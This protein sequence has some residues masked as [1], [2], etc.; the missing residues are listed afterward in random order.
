MEK[1]EDEDNTQAVK[2]MRKEAEEGLQTLKI[3]AKLC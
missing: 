3:F 2:V 1:E